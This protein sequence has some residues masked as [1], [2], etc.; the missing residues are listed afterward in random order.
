LTRVRGGVLAVLMLVSQP[1]WARQVV[2]S[3]HAVQG[4]VF[5]SVAKRPLAGAVVHVAMR[6]S[7]SAPVT[8]A[9]DASGRYRVSDLPAGV[10]VVGFY[11]DALIV[12]GLDAPSQAVDLTTDT[13]ATVNLAIPSSLMVRALRCGADSLRADRGMLV[14]FVRDALNRAAIPGASVRLEWGGLAFDSANV[15]TVTERAIARIDADGAYA[16]CGVP[17]DAPLELLAHAPAHRALAGPVVTVPMSGIWRLDLA[18]ADSAPDQ[19]AAIIRGRVLNASGHAVA[20]GRVVVE[21][22]QREVPVQDGGFLM[23]GLPA[24]SWIVEARVIGTEPQAMLV[25]AADGAVTPVDITVREQS[26]RLEAVTVVGKLD[27]N[28]RVLEEVLR[29]KRTGAGTVFLPGNIHLRMAMYTSDVFQNARGFTYLSA[30]DIGGRRT[31]DGTPC[32]PVAVYLDDMYVATGF[33]Q[34]DRLVPVGDVLAIET[35]PD[36]QFAPVRYRYA[37]GMLTGRNDPYTRP[38]AVVAVWTKRS[39]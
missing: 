30:T 4:I 39:Y 29:R 11:H 10:Y 2:P 18:F 23:A 7:A 27:R 31:P 38:C 25:E 37:P 20:S 1:A 8:A 33:D 12:L 6:E 14:G 13:L 28:T 19:G 9:T 16:V 15:R 26:Q 22:L 36:M 5:D 35:Y 24:G 3:R 17:L 21:T 32:R 34:L